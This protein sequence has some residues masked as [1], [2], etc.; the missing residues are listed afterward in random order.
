MKFVF[1]SVLACVFMYVS[2]ST[3]AEEVNDTVASGAVLR[4][5]G[6]LPEAV[7]ILRAAVDKS[8]DDPEASFQLGK[9][10]NR[11]ADKEAET[12][13]KKA[14]MLAPEH[15]AV[16]LELGMFYFNKDIYAEAGDY[17]ENTISI[18]P[19]TEYARNAQEYL[20]KI[21]ERSNGSKWDMN[22]LTGL[23]YD[24]NVIL[25]GTG[26]PLPAGY[27]GKSDWSGIINLKGAYSFLKKDQ[28]EMKAGYSLYQSLHTRLDDFDITQNL[29]DLSVAYGVSPRIQLK[30]AYVFE[31][32]LLGGDRYDHAHNIKPSLLLNF[33]DWGRAAIDYRYR[34]TTYTSSDNFPANPER[35]GDNH[36]AGISYSIPV[37]KAC[38]AW[39]AYS[40]DEDTTRHDYWNY[41][42]DRVFAGFR[43]SLPFNMVADIN[44]EYYRKGYAA[45]DPAFGVTRHDHQYSGSFSLTKTFSDRISVVLGEQYTRNDSNIGVFDYVRATTSLF[46]NVRFYE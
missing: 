10:L 30:A 20:K 22:F 12:H 42:G 34:N 46:M 43:S 6:N 14:L 32:L 5:T 16:N 36:Y 35:N 28:I 11:M 25:N 8:S 23:Q 15:P 37:G 3:A 4:Q 7:T 21:D 40:H 1:A 38:F 17:F 19:G 31:Y 27:T 45:D 13:L 9:A 18:A 24:S 44:G 26:M 39:A 2:V 33:G 41:H 29:I